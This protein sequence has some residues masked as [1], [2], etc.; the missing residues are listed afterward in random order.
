MEHI[1][2]HPYAI[3]LAK[4]VAT[5]QLQTAALVNLNGLACTATLVCIVVA[6]GN[7][8]CLEISIKKS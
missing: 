5:A 6:L 1:V 2:K 7:L 3:H 8:K 4:T